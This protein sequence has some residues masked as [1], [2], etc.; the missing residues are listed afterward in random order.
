[1]HA[2][3]IPGRPFDANFSVEIS[4][5]L[6]LRYRLSFL[7]P[8]MLRRLLTSGGEDDESLVSDAPLFKG[9]LPLFSALDVDIFFKD[10]SLSAVDSNPRTIE[11]KKV[12]ID[13]IFIIGKGLLVP[14]LKSYT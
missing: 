11:I 2:Y 5:V 7:L 14:P 13:I 12:E 4:D 9:G 8:A 6:L 3:C 10:V 1:M